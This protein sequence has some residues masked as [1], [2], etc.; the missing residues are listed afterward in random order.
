M[1]GDVWLLMLFSTMEIYEET[2]KEKVAGAYKEYRNIMY[3]IAFSILKDKMLAEDAVH[4]AFIAFINN[5]HKI[6]NINCHKTRTY[7]LI[8]V[9]NASIKIYNERKK[10][11]VSEVNDY[12]LLDYEIGTDEKA[13]ANDS[14]RRLFN[15]VKSMKKKYADV[16]LLKFYCELENDEIATA[17]N[18]TEAN[19]R[20]RLQLAR[21]KLKKMME[22]SYND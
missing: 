22:D 17:L 10:H 1:E 16:I 18:I 12:E 7:L 11:I 14:V 21:K 9:R 4:N 3:H 5:L 6:N 13:E 15:M 20:K 8:I 2:D 19:V